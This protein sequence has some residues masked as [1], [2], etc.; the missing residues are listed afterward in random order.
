MGL[1]Y[2][3][4]ASLTVLCPALFVEV[5]GEVSLELALQLS[6]LPQLF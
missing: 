5:F 6:A 3:K 2:V 1:A 4:S